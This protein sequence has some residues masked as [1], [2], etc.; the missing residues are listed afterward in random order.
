MESKEIQWLGYPGY[1]GSYREDRDLYGKIY[2]DLKNLWKAEEI[3]E[4]KKIKGKKKE[5]KA[6]N[7]EKKM[8]SIILELG[9]ER[10][11]N[12]EALEAKRIEKN[13]NPEVLEAK[14][15]EESINPKVLE[16]KS[17]EK[18]SNFKA[19]R[20]ELEE[21]SFSNPIV[22]LDSPPQSPSSKEEDFTWEAEIRK[23]R[24]IEDPSNSYYIFG[25][26]PLI[27]KE[28]PE[29]KE[30][31]YEMKSA[32]IAAYR[33]IQLYGI[34][35]NSNQVYVLDK[36]FSQNPT[37]LEAV[38]WLA[39]KCSQFPFQKV[40]HELGFNFDLEELRKSIDIHR[41][42]QIFDKLDYKKKCDIMKE[43]KFQDK[44]PWTY[45]LYTEL[46]HRYLITPKNEYSQILR[47][48]EIF[49][50]GTSGTMNNKEWMQ[51]ISNKIVEI[52]YKLNERMFL[53]EF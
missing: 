40:Y 38:N 21:G 51:L 14:S 35:S 8:R 20:H 3:E 49:D 32:L 47:D 12:P 16:A 44:L 45:K 50:E 5:K 53:D 27:L 42:L 34:G 6:E 22:L 15:I 31:P 9:A 1:V 41:K 43:V 36:E 17:R 23:Q 52:A 37:V 25:I 2:T 10:N 46:I 28:V 19:K 11:N 24:K 18:K 7:P 4:N 30:Y 13:N 39:K 48:V 29:G 33:L 26:N